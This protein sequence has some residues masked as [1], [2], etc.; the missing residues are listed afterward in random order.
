M[1]AGPLPGS[2]VAWNK[3]AGF[4]TRWNVGRPLALLAAALFKRLANTGLT[5][6][7]LVE[8][9]RRVGSEDRANAMAA[10]VGRVTVVGWS[11]SSQE[12]QPQA[13]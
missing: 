2:M 3:G 6:A 11:M 10:G 7:K 13:G 4:A 5:G 12:P 8:A 1:G 9:T